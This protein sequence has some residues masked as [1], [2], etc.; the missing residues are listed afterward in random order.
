MGLVKK[1]SRGGLT[2]KSSIQGKMLAG[3]GI[4]K[5]SLTQYIMQGWQEKLLFTENARQGWYL[6][7]F[8]LIFQA[9]QRLKSWGASV[10]KLIFTENARQA[11]YKKPFNLIFQAAQ[12]LKS[13]GAS[14]K[15][16]QYKENAT[17]DWYRKNFFN[18]IC[19]VGLARKTS[20]H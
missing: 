14:V 20:F 12:R 8:N 7:S 17:Q 19:Q 10:K 2:L 15:E 5:A 13:W 6:K 16:A 3:N 11:W 18:S 9:A 1:S 4:E